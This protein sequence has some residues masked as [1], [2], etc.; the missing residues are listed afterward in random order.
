MP[1]QCMRHNPPPETHA[2][3]LLLNWLED[4]K[5][6]LL[7]SLDLTSILIPI[8]WEILKKELAQDEHSIPRIVDEF[9][10]EESLRQVLIS[11]LIFHMI[12]TEN[13]LRSSGSQ[14]FLRSVSQRLIPVTNF[15]IVYF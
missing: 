2:F 14:V 12:T 5:G 15:R 9:N 4:G 8:R 1:E 13:Q 10:L 6:L 11:W 7:Q 3:V